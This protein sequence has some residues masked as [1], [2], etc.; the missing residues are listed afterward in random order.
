MSETQF[1]SRALEL[2]KLGMGSVSPNPMV[3][4]VIVHNGLIIGEGWHQKYGGPHAEVNA[5]NAVKE[6]AIL[7]DSEIY[8]TLEPCSHYGMTPPCADLLILHRVKKVI[9]CNEDPFPLVAGKGIQKLRDAGIEVETGLLNSRGRHLNRR[10]FKSVESQRPYVILKWAETA[11][12]YMAGEDQKPLKITNDITDIRVHKWR[13]EEDA[14]MVGTRTAAIDNPS[15]SVR[16]WEGKDPVRVVI[17]RDLILNKDLKIFD[18]SQ[19]TIIFN[20][21]EDK[22][23]GNNQFIK[24]LPAENNLDEILSRL[25]GQK[26]R[27]LFVEGGAGLLNSFIKH[28]LFDEIRVLKS[29]LSIKK[30]V[31]APQ[32]PHG[33]R[34]VSSEQVKGDE[35]RIFS[36]G[37]QPLV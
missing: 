1:M 19:K 17:D 15:L 16:H 30:G 14:I 25:Q 32:L 33:I 24:I 9:I 31:A 34:P 37:F 28:K 20:E 18:G 23:Q 4:C 12:G 27:S 35:I 36:S 10:F 26:I 3:G 6:K 22:Q 11:D 7:P 8:V 5:I 29:S 2:A 21:R 13:S